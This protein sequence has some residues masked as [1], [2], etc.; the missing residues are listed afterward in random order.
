MSA[1]LG[2]E[3]GSTRIKAVLIDENFKPLASGSHDWEN[4]LVDG[5]WTYD[6]KDVWTGLQ[7]SFR[8][9]NDGVKSRSGHPL[10]RVDAVCISAMMHGYLVFDK[11]DKLLVPFR[12]WR[13]TMTEKAAADLTARFGFNIPQRWSIAHL[14]QAVLNKEAHVRDAAFITTLAG[15]V[16]W[17]LTGK[18]VL[19]VGDASGVFPIDSTTN[20]YDPR[21]ARQF[22]E[23]AGGSDGHIKWKLAE[24]LPKAL[25]AGDHAG[26]LSAEGALLLDPSGGLQAGV[27]F[28][29]RKATREPAWPPP[30]ALRS[31]PATC[32][33]ALRFSP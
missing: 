24:L 19:G 18:K 9:L 13:N 5:V 7:D 10:T 17:K 23:L 21:L 15:Y 22:D 6:L 31:G 11:A 29:P 1:F 8:T 28:C 26:S 16:H 32:P 14:W 30:T 25:N 2:I 33:R 3:F 20:D 12:T 4:K 27:P